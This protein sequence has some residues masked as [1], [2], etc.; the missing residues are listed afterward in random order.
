M[1]ILSSCFSHFHSGK[2]GATIVSLPKVRWP[3]GLAVKTETV[4]ASCGGFTLFIYSQAV[5]WSL[6]CERTK[7][8]TAVWN[9]RNIQ[10]LVHILLLPIY[11]TY[12]LHEL[13]RY[14]SMGWTNKW[15]PRALGK[16]HWHKEE[17]A[18]IKQSY[19]SE[20][21]RIVSVQRSS[22]QGPDQGPST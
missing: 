8:L 13:K 14:S 3:D 19:K 20:R 1:E 12:L 5:L 9:A 17:I 15:V 6:R 10:V 16:S 2:W 11:Y 21:K 22:R 7:A 4:M 18:D